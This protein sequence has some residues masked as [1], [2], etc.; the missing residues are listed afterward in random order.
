MKRGSY[1][2]AVFSILFLSLAWYFSHDVRGFTQSD[3][4]VKAFLPGHLSKSHAFLGNQCTACHTPNQGVSATQCMS[5][6]ANN[7]NLLQRQSTAFH[8]NITSCKECHREHQ[9]GSSPPLSMDHVA[10]AS[11]G[12]RAHDENSDKIEN[13]ILR[14]FVEKRPSQKITSATVSIN[15]KEPTIVSNL[16]CVSCHAT[17][18]KHQGLFGK[19]CLSCH[20][21]QSWRITEYR[22]PSPNSRSCAECHQAPPSHYME[23]FEMISEKVAGQEHA[24]VNQ[25]FLCHQTTSWNDIKGVGWYKHH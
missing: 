11:L 24:K 1:L 10:L 2:I 12:A 6:H 19:S 20:G 5:C 18:D 17:K 13:Q 22:H 4:T 21:T 7:R 3:V 23:H 25:C 9:G 8:A 15:P 14:S 16:N